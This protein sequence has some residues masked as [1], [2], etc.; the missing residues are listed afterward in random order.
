LSD[1]I[2]SS[3]WTTNK[4]VLAVAIA[5]AL[6]AG[7]AMDRFVLAPAPAAT[8]A[9]TTEEEAPTGILKLD[10]ARIRA[11]GIRLA[12]VSGGDADSQ[13]IAQATVA[14]TP[15]GAA[16]IGARADGTVT[17]IRK[18]L[19]DEVAKGE[20]IGTLQSREA[21]RLAE[22]RAA[23][24]ARLVRAEQAFARQKNLMAQGATA[25]QE[26][27]AA[28]AEYQVARAE[29][30]RAGLA[31]SASG[32]S[33][34]GVSLNIISPVAG[35][36]TVAS[37]VLGAYVIAGSELFRVADPSRLEVQAAVPTADAHRIKPG[38]GAVIV[39]GDRDIVAMVRAITPDVN[40]QS[41]AATVVLTPKYGNMLQPG[42][43]VSARIMVAHGHSD[44]A[45]VLV[46]TEAV[47]K[48][49]GG[50]AVFVRA[51][52]E[53]QL[54]QVVTGVENGGLIE[55]RAGL[56]AGENIATTNAFLLKAEMLKGS[57][58]DD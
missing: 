8:T 20:T 11:A 31:A 43:Y 5:F 55:V 42:Q 23:A 19:G 37:A 39:A 51:G 15:E 30:G 41:R 14:A 13:V 12:K 36:I 34:D 21:A 7:I 56:K 27:D 33:V 50:D 28:Q 48:I 47:Q 26:F 9:I 44:V 38:D 35:R 49:E 40:Q 53:F 54:R 3:A 6:A 22:E 45:T 17:S 4:A 52:D 46:P 18:R 25:R 10:E 58:S 2:W 29:L 32:L 1:S 24:Q 57:A 16:I